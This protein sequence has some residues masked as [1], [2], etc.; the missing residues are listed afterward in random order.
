MPVIY[1]N[2]RGVVHLPKESCGHYFNGFL[3][4]MIVRML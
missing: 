1:N 2:D 3:H 4:D